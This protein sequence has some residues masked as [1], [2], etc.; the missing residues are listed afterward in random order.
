MVPR[1]DTEEVR[2]HRGRV[3]EEERRETRSPP[4]QRN[5][6]QRQARRRMRM[7]QRPHRTHNRNLNL[8]V[9]TKDLFSSYYPT[10]GTESG[11]QHASTVAKTERRTM[12][13]NT[14]RQHQ[15]LTGTRKTRR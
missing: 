13:I 11:K 15:S 4:L 8:Q 2:Y 12:G 1:Q 3:G 10:G 7:Q 14:R 5:T 6:P 9:F